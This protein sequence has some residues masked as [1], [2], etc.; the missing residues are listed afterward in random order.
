[1]AFYYIRPEQIHIRPEP[2]ISA[3]VRRTRADMVGVYLSHTLCKIVTKSLHHNSEFQLMTF[4][5]KH[6]VND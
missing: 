4:L 3:R 5:I 2:A 1:M 6:N